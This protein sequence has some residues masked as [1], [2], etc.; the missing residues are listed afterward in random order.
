M[1]SKDA[2]SNS[3]KSTAAL[4]L[5]FGTPFTKIHS[6]SH[7]GVLPK[8]AIQYGLVV[9]DRKTRRVDYSV[10]MA[11][12]NVDD[13][14]VVLLSAGMGKR[15]GA[16]IPKQYLK[17]LGKEIALRSL[18]VFLDVAPKEIVIVC[19]EEWRNLFEAYLSARGDDV[20]SE[21]KFALGGEERQDSVQNGLAQLTTTYAAVHDS[22]RPLV[23]A[24][25]VADVVSDARLHGAALL[26]VPTKAT[27]KMAKLEESMVDTT[28]KRELLWEAHT[29]QVIRASLLRDGFDYVQK[30]DLAVTDDVSI[31]ELLGE[32]VKLTLGKYTNIKVTTP[33]D[34]GLAET[35]LKEREKEP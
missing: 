29:P 30:N 27:I 20:K 9:G 31:V 11:S 32:P 22:A 18:D 1:E 10:S 34:I 14:G 3:L 17:L 16:N 33:E 28:P 8:S 35:I 21:I 13:V 15:M 26:A 4:L 25:E 24:A 23:T 7:G 6:K 19:A 12:T 2:L 5:E